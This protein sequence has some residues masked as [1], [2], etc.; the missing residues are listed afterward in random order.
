MALKFVFSLVICLYFAVLAQFPHSMDDSGVH[1]ERLAKVNLSPQDKQYIAK[2]VLG[3][4]PSKCLSFGNTL[5]GEIGNIRIFKTELAAGE[6]DLLIQAS[7]GCNCG[8]TGNC[9]FWILRK[10]SSGFS[11]LLATRMVQ[12]F[13]VEATGMNGHK[14]VMTSDHGSATS[15]DLAL[16]QFDGEKY[17]NT[18]CAEEIYSEKEDGTISDKPMVTSVK[19]NSQ[20]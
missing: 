11:T 9:S 6:Q 7:D 10:N 2:L 17:R 13:S 14:D 3:N 8:G 18:R 19:C 4:D 16:Y 12:M 15:S 5:Q 20:K 1:I